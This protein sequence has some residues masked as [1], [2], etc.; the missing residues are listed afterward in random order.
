MTGTEDP[1]TELGMFLRARR[2]QLSPK[3]LGFPNAGRRRTPGL[4]REEVAVAAGLSATWYTYLEQGRDR[5]VSPAVLNSLART[6]QMTEDERRY[7]HLLMYGHVPHAQKLDA[8]VPID[9]LVRDVVATTDLHPYPVY[10]ADR[11]CNVVAWNGAF[12]E[13]YDD[14][15]RL[16]V[17][18]RNLMRWLF[19]SEHAR[20]RF[21]DW[22]SVA[23]DLV[24]RWRLES[25]SGTTESATKRITDGLKEESDL[26]R[27]WWGER[28]VLEHRIAVRRFRRPGHRD[29]DL[30]VVPMRT[31]YD[32]APGIFFHFPEAGSTN[33]VG[34]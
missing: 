21:T 24:A 28:I 12:A 11:V 6:L 18:D 26:F 34:S 13:W 2:E 1:R 32:S 27:Q 9:Q 7:M 20:E 10:A 19:L 33:G 3:D 14:L 23:R 5:D 16:P 15:G 25:A 30:R 8:E 29:C 31:I 22:E 17:A 4:R